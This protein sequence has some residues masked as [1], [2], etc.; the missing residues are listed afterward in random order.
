VREKG[1]ELSNNNF[2]AQYPQ[3]FHLRSQ[4]GGETPSTSINEEHFHL[5]SIATKSNY[6]LHPTLKKIS[7]I[8]KHDEFE[9]DNLEKE[10]ESGEN[11]EKSDGSFNDEDQTWGKAW[12]PGFGPLNVPSSPTTTKMSNLFNMVYCKICWLIY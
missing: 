4:L 8:H 3:D 5:Q 9:L 2:S 1:Q 7:T 11:I 12:H 10:I 6:I